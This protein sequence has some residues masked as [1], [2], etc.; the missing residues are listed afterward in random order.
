MKYKYK[1]N[2]EGQCVVLDFMPDGYVLKDGEQSGEHDGRGMPNV[3]SLHSDNYISSEAFRKLRAERNTLL[4]QT[5]WWGA[6]DQ[7]MT[8]DQKAFRQKLRDFPSTTTPELDENGELT[9][10][11]WPTKP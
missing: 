10:V 7:T 6:S 1:L 9:G 5:D 8:D 3:W 11:T 4:S 2:E